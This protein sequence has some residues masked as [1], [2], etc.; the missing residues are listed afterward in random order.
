M[1]AFEDAAQVGAV[2][3]LAKSFERTLESGLVEESHL[4]S[5][6]LETRDAEALAILDG[7]DEVGRLQ[8]RLVGAGIQPCRA[9][10]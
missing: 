3:R 10:T 9:A 5:D 8:Q 7:T 6:F 2:R 4:Q 1:S